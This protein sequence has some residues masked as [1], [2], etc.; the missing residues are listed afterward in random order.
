MLGDT[1]GKM[2]LSAVYRG[3]YDVLNDNAFHGLFTAKL[4]LPMVIGQSTEA[5]WVLSYERGDDLDT[6][7]EIDE[8][9]LGLSVRF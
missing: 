1:W 2:E 8:L 7:E 6:Y 5:G 9:K 4:Q 3:V